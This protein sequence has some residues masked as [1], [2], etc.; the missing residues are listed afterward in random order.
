MLQG[1][2]GGYLSKPSTTFGNDQEP[3]LIPVITKQY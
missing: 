1:K 3:D 2:E